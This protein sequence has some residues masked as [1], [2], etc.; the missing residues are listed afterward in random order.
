MR[1]AIKNSLGQCSNM[2]EDCESRE[3]LKDSRMEVMLSM[4]KSM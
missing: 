3:P 1:D 4:S 2:S